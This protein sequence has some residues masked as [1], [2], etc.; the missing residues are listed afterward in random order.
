MTEKTGSHFEH[1]PA[2]HYFVFAPSWRRTVGKVFPLRNTKPLNATCNPLARQQT[3]YVSIESTAGA[4]H[5]FLALQRLINH[6][7]CT[8]N[9][10]DDY[11]TPHNF[12][13]TCKL[14][15]NKMECLGTVPFEWQTY[16]KI[17]QL[18]CCALR[19]KGN[20]GSG[21]DEAGRMSKVLRKVSCICTN[22][23]NQMESRNRKEAEGAKLKFTDR[24][25]DEAFCVDFKSDRCNSQRIQ[26]TEKANSMQSVVTLEFS[27]TQQQRQRTTE[28][29]FICSAHIDVNN[30][31]YMYRLLPTEIDLNQYEW[32]RS[33][34]G[35]VA[36]SARF[37]SL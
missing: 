25:A 34:F 28:Q 4:I 37:L 6:W 9:A 30:H 13:K 33:P 36:F 26:C 31:L 32:H 11:K 22:C 7:H 18:N 2:F 21:L 20:G 15:G 12:A 35:T 16:L 29:I 23:M 8:L 19:A 5:N 27:S 24:G 17:H 3:K 1:V 10:F 14:S